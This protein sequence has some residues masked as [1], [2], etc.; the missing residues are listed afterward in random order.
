MTDYVTRYNT[1]RRL[2]L[3]G[4]WQTAEL[5]SAVDYS[6]LQ[7]YRLNDVLLGSWKNPSIISDDSHFILCYLVS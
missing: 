1:L 2:A 3:L 4:L 6:G 5:C 7:I